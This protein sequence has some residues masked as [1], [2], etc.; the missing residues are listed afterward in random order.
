MLGVQTTVL[1]RRRMAVFYS[2]PQASHKKT[3]V[4]NGPPGHRAAAEAVKNPPAG[5][6][7]PAG[8]KREQGIRCPDGIRKAN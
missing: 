2:L 6:E 1:K 8:E 4:G 3:I 7:P 5:A